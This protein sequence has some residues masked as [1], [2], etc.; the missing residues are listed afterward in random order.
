MEKTE[1][2]NGQVVEELLDAVDGLLAELFES[3]FS[4]IYDHTF[5]GLK[6]YEKRAEQIGLSGLAKL[7][8]GLFSRLEQGR[9]Q[10]K[11]ETAAVLEIY[12]QI[13]RYTEICRKRIQLDMALCYYE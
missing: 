8:S 7:L 10:I 2:E 13:Y 12:G 1:L 5:D 11:R 9:H 3:G 4:T 6:E